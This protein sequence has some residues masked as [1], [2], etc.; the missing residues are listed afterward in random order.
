MNILYILGNGFDLAQG[1]KTN[2]SDFY[3]YLRKVPTKS[4][5][6]QRV[7]DEIES[8][9]RSWADMEEALG[10]YTSKWKDS[11]D[12]LSVVSF[13]KV[14]L[15]EYLQG[16]NDAVSGMSLSTEKLLESISFPERFLFPKGRYIFNSS[17]FGL[18]PKRDIRCVTFNYTNTFEHV[19]APAISENGTIKEDGGIKIDFKEMM[20]IHGSLNGLT[21]LGVNDAE[22]MSNIAFRKNQRI[23]DEFVKPEINEACASDR[24]DYFE[25]WIRGAQI[26]V[27]FGVS[28][29]VTDNKWWQAI[30]AALNSGSSYSRPFVFYFPYDPEKNTKKNETSI[31]GWSNDYIS[32][33]QERFNLSIPKEEILGRICVGINSDIF[34]LR[35]K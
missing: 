3:D 28:L 18:A 21:L 29:G 32:L 7:I 24:N 2:Y 27:L 15:T 20:H 23:I 33:L 10:K 9:Y 17:S 8:D 1:L 11:R 12:F 16:Q 30:G 31:R 35:D 14:H 25:Q 19:L 4:D 26:I 6:E 34:D 13:L 5:L 22:Q